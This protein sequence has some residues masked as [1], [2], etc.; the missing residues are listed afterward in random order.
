MYKDFGAVK[1]IWKP[2]RKISVRIEPK[3]VFTNSLQFGI[4]GGFNKDEDFSAWIGFQLLF[5]YIHL[6]FHLLLD[7]Y[8]CEVGLT[9]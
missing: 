1:A 9:D 7:E 6:E 8:H 5:L 2:D 4:N 3:V